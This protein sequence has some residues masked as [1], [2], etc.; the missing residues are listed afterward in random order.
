MSG[1]AETAT[2]LEQR[3]EALVPNH[4]E[5]LTFENP[6]PLFKVPGFDCSDLAPSLAQAWHA[7]AAVQRRHLH[8]EGQT[9]S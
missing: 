2:A 6:W 5:I 4:P 1:Y 9:T 8:Q 7:L 3:I